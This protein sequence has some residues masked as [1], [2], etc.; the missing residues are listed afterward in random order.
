[1]I[2]SFVVIKVKVENFHSQLKNHITKVIDFN[3]GRHFK[4]IDLN[5]VE[6]HITKVIDFNFGRHFKIIDL[7]EVD[8]RIYLP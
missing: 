6:N 8:T 4:I 1:M 5:E 3:F 2:K 7:N